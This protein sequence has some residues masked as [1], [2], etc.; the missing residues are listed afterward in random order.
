PTAALY[1]ARDGQWLW[2]QPPETEVT[3]P[4]TLKVPTALRRI[5]DGA[6]RLEVS[7]G[8]LANALDE[9]DVRFPGLKDRVLD[10]ETGNIHPFISIFLNG[11][12]VHYLRGLET[13]VKDGDEIIIVPAIAGG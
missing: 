5:T 9:L 7:A 6:D 13:G 10:D 12:D 11:D 3:M 4:A 8:S 1:W 2:G